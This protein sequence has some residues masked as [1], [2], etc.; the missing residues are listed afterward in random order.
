MGGVVAMKRTTLS[1]SLERKAILE[2]ISIKIQSKTLEPMTWTQFA[3]YV[4][5]NYAEEA[6]KDIIE[7]HRKAG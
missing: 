5:E 1:V 6:A 4:I 3:I 7:E 2:Q